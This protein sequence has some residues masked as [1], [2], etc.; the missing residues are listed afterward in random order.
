V[1][2]STLTILNTVEP[3]HIT[4]VVLRLTYQVF[5]RIDLM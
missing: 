2:E 5:K 1:N 3:T 4:C